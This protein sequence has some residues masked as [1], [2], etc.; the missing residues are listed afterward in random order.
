M[1]LAELR[2]LEARFSDER[3]LPRRYRVRAEPPPLPE[4]AP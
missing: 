1:A 3:G 2:A 4:F